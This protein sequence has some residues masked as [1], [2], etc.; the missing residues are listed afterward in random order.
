MT[1]TEAELRKA[2]DAV[3]RALRMLNGHSTTLLPPPMKDSDPA[4]NH[5]GVTNEQSHSAACRPDKHPAPYA[6]QGP[7]GSSRDQNQVNTNEAAVNH[8]RI[9]PEA[10]AAVERVLAHRAGV[11]AEVPGQEAWRTKTPTHQATKCVSHVK[12]FLAG[13]RADR[14]TGESP[15]AHAAARALLALALE[16]QRR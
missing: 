12:E 16:L 8:S 10:L 3:E 15:L 7:V 1:D 4:A 9:P 6:G 14:D 11:V 5:D 13:E 2:V